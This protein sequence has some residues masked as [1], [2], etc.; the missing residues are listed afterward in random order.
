[1]M[2]ELGVIDGDTLNVTHLD[3]LPKGR[4]VKLQPHTL[5][6]VLFCVPLGA[7]EELKGAPR[8]IFT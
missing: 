5:L 8:N 6:A 2:T 7:G 3:T 1:M 4:Y